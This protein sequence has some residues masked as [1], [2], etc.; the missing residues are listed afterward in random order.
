MNDKD[1]NDCFTHHTILTRLTSFWLRHAFPDPGQILLELH[2]ADTH[3][4]Y[5]ST[6]TKKIGVISSTQTKWDIR[7]LYRI[8]HASKLRQ[9][10]LKILQLGHFVSPSLIRMELYKSTV[11]TSR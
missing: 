5:Q 4:T 7:Y 6:T 2:Q 9:Q 8:N 3:S 11:D 10:S 1:A